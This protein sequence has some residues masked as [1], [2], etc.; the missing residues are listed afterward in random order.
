MH[1]KRFLFFLLFIFLILVCYGCVGST[2]LDIITICDEISISSSGECFPN[3]YYNGEL[4]SWNNY[5]FIDEKEYIYVYNG[6]IF[7]REGSPLEFETVV[8]VMS[9]NND[10]VFKKIKINKKNI[11]I[12]EINIVLNSRVYCDERVYFSV[13]C[14][15]ENAVMQDYY[16]EFDN[17]S[18]IAEKTKSYFKLNSNAN[19]DEIITMTIHD[20]S[21]VSACK[22]IAV[23]EPIKVYN[24]ND[25]IKVKN[26]L[27]AKYILMKDIDFNGYSW[28][29]IS[30]FKGI[31]DGNGKTISNLS[32]VIEKSE[33][34]NCD[35]YGMFQTLSGTVKNVTFS[36]LKIH[37][38]KYRD[39][40]T[41]L[42]VGGICAVLSGGRI[43]NCHIS[44]NEIFGD[45]YRE[46][47][48]LDDVKAQ[49][50][51]FA[52]AMSSG[53]IKNCSIDAGSVY[54]KAGCGNND[55]NCHANV[56]GI[57][58]EQNGGSIESCSRNSAVT[59]KSVTRGNTAAW[60]WH[61]SSLF[62]RAGG[63]VGYQGGSGK[64]IS[65]SS[66]S[67]KV[68]AEKDLNS[69]WEQNHGNHHMESGAICGKQE[70]TVS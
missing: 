37:V 41:N 20:S 3:I 38:Y 45:H 36:N 46:V 61:H 30:T 35:K 44:V 1:C 62:S 51:S 29:P 64:I 2:E 70:G 12:T 27:S 15:P 23:E 9:R 43:E 50:G 39:G 49:V 33:D 40:L 25:L 32:Y 10:K 57:V 54:G 65:C 11:E 47:N 14:K 24:A 21:G 56:G 53:V 63:I 48:D 55:G 69:G 34:G 26:D 58:G 6:L 5:C 28:T 17:E 42:Y 18:L 31:L 60:L 16:I 68:S 7:I 13:D 66:T 67:T 52:G 59:V 8:N 22:A 19:K 4:S